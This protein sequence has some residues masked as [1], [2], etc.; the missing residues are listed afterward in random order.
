MSLVNSLLTAEACLVVCDTLAGRVGSRGPV[1]YGCKVIPIQRLGILISAT[2][3][4][5][6]F[7]RWDAHLQT[8]PARDLDTV[9]P[10]QPAIL[11]ALLADLGDRERH[12]S[13]IFIWGW[14]SRAG[15]VQ[16]WV[17]HSRDGFTPVALEDGYT[18]KPPPRDMAAVEALPATD[19]AIERLTQIVALQVADDRAARRRS[20]VVG[21]SED[22]PLMLGGDLLAF[23]LR[24]PSP[25]LPSVSIESWSVGPMDGA[26]RERARVL[27]SL[28]LTASPWRRAR[29]S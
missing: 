19:N 22:G 29:L 18:L 5:D 4:G 15:R 7:Q 1:G 6:L 20:E 16:G 12:R 27:T 10:H 8:S 28:A 21:V 24:A 2:G 9:L 3:S 26:A 23:I 25:N 14:S 17:M 13:S 11:R